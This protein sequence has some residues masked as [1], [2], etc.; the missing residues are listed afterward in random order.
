MK[1]GIR[2]EAATAFK[3]APGTDDGH[4]QLPVTRT[5]AGGAIDERTDIWSTGVIMYEMVAGVVPFSGVTSSHTIVQI[6]EKDP[7]PLSKLGNAPPEL[8]RIVE[9][10]MAKSPDERYQTAKD[11]LIDLR[12]LKKRLDLEMEIQ[13]TSSPR[14]QYPVS[15]ADGKQRFISNN[16][17]TG[18]ADSRTVV[19]EV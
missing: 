1:S 17:R 16:Y 14:V 18:D 9:K 7:A 12:S 8:E 5:G 10:A 15:F 2:P 4:D 11:M 13:R 6:L 19:A 3:T